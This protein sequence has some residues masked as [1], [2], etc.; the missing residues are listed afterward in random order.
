M[1][2]FI[3]FYP[4]CKNVTLEILASQVVILP[5]KKKLKRRLTFSFYRA[6]LSIRGTS[7][8]S[9]SVRVCPSQVGVLSKRLNESS[10]FL[11]C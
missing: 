7:H 9:V 6:M 8:G 11:A 1:Q 3:Q 10:W 4:G 2:A 5:Q